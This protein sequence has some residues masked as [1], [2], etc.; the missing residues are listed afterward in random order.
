M[1]RMRKKKLDSYNQE[2]TN[3]RNELVTAL[4]NVRFKKNQN[5]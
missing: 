3:E 5:I 4:T 1:K 2:D